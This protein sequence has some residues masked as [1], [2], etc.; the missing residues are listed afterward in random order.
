MQRTGFLAVLLAA[1]IP[2]VGCSK[3]TAMMEAAERG[4]AA[5]LKAALE[6]GADPNTQTGMEGMTALMLA[7]Q[8]GHADCVKALLDAGADPI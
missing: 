3:V 2:Y 6:G 5:Q 7:S 1:L 8:G 4:D